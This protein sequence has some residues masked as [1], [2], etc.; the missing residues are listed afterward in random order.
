VRLLILDRRWNQDWD[1]GRARLEVAAVRLERLQ[2]GRR[3]L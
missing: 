2:E 1:Y 3:H